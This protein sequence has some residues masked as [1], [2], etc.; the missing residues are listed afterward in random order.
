MHAGQE[1][2][3][4]ERLLLRRPVAEDL[5]DVLRLHRDPDAIRH[6]PGD[7]LLDESDARR[8]L[9]AWDAQWAAGLGYWILVDLADDAFVGVCGVKAVDLRGLPV[10]NLLYRLAP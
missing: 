2:V 8:R 7:A 9:A 10:W 3:R 4:T 6:N 5:G 1:R